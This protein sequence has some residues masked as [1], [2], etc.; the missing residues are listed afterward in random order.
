MY[1]TVY[2]KSPAHI[3]GLYPKLKAGEITTGEGDLAD[4]TREKGLNQSLPFKHLSTNYYCFGPNA[5][6]YPF[7]LELDLERLMFI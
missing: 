5:T 3:N 2:F 6:F 4:N 7:S 1:N